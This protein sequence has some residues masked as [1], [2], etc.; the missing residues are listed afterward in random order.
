MNVCF[1]ERGNA[2]KRVVMW[3]VVVVLCLRVRRIVVD[4]IVGDFVSD[5][6]GPRLFA[7][8]ELV[9]GHQFD[10]GG[11]VPNITQVGEKVIIAAVEEIG[12]NCLSI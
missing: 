7:R 11:G 12:V 2:L 8:I 10:F 6:G 5:V 3:D 1:S 4:L 9:V